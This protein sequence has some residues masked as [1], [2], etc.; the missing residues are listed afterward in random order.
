MTHILLID[1]HVSW[2]QFAAKVLSGAGYD[3]KTAVS[4]DM[5]GQRYLNE[6]F[7][8]IFVGLDQAESHLET[9]ADWAKGQDHPQRFVVM[10]P[11]RQTFDTVR[12]V[13]K[14]GAYDVV[15][16]PYQPDALLKTV[17]EEVREAKARNGHGL[18]ANQ[19][20]LT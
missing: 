16:K 6:D 15:N 2:L 18:L 13:L 17:A 1:Q 10:F 7:D 14:A 9:L 20:P 8:L 12:I 19:T 5:A 11:V 3:V 4:L